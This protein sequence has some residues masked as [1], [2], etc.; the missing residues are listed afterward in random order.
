[1]THIIIT[2]NISNLA[3][4]PMGI[5]IEVFGIFRSSEKLCF[6][7]TDTDFIANDQCLFIVWTLRG[8]RMVIYEWANSLGV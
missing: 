7:V 5:R 2:G 6:G 3:C 4:I 1:M 8:N